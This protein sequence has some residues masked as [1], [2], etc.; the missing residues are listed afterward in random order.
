MAGRM[1]LA[2]GPAIRSTFRSRP[3]MDLPMDITVARPCEAPA[4]SSRYDSIAGS[5]CTFEKNAPSGTA[6]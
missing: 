5:S 4:S 3:W 2:P 1:A 6:P